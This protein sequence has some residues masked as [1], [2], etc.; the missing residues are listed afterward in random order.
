[1]KKN[2]SAILLGTALVLSSAF[3]TFG[4][5]KDTG[6]SDVSADN[7]YLDG[8]QFC[9]DNGII[10]LGEFES[11]LELFTGADNAKVTI[12]AVEQ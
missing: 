4:A 5:V 3:M 8:I 7:S 11:G 6:F 9:V 12:E 10:K 2:L 1:M